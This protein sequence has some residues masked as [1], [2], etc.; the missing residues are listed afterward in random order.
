VAPALA[1]AA[2]ASPLRVATRTPPSAGTNHLRSVGSAQ[3]KIAQAAVASPAAAL[4]VDH[5]RV[6]S[7]ES[8]TSAESETQEMMGIDEASGRS[9]F[10]TS[11]RLRDGLRA[12]MEQ[13]KPPPPPPA[14]ETV[15][16][17]LAKA[18]TPSKPPQIK[19]PSAA[20]RIEEHLRTRTV[21]RPA[22]ALAPSPSGPKDPFAFDE[23]DI[24]ERPA[25]VYHARAASTPLRAPVVGKATHPPPVL[26]GAPPARFP[27]AQARPA[28]ALAP[29]TVT[30]PPAAAAAGVRMPRPAEE[31]LSDARRV[32]ERKQQQQ[33]QQTLSQYLPGK[34][35]PDDGS[36]VEVV[37]EAS[38]AARPYVDVA[39]AGT[40]KPK[41]RKPKRAAVGN[42]VKM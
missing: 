13:R 14:P 31:A 32:L 23:P 42:L 10:E 8:D 7:D 1:A 11:A 27:H 22:L 15:P 5:R 19:R 37:E 29:L 35:K 36:D 26:P 30:V 12:Q 17:R 6:V 40:R 28:V 39:R 2:V 9:L 20:L 3:Q 24:P 41:K 25:A 4:V 33:Q 38:S 21:T 18:A 16:T 34:R